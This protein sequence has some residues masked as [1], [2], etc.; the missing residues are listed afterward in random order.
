MPRNKGRSDKHGA[1]RVWLR[2]VGLYSVGL[3]L[4]LVPLLIFA[5]G[6]LIF[7]IMPWPQ[8]SAGTD[9]AYVAVFVYPV[10]GI[11]ALVCSLQR[12]ARF[13]WIGIGLLSAILLTGYLAW[14][15]LAHSNL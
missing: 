12:Q 8:Q 2:R 4:G 3:G 15:A 5:I 10:A 13:R 9:I 6:T 14:Q 11:I 1:T 7:N